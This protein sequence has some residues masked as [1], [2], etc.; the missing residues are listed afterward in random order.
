MSLDFWW[1]GEY[2]LD[3]IV[4]YG[5]VPIIVPRVSGIHMVLDSFEPIHGVLL[6]EGEDIDPSLYDSGL[7]S[8]ELSPEELEE[9]R[10]LHASD[11]A[12]DKE[13]DSI[14]FRLA[15]LCLDRNIPYLGICRGSQVNIYY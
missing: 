11:T 14:E 9:V 7:S 1:L 10:R 2:H 4:N 6:C 3:L 12:I 13:K 15:K 5:A 8:G